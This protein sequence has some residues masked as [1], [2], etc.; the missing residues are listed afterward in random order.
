MLFFYCFFSIAFFLS[1]SHIPFDNS[2]KPKI[3]DKGVFET[4]LKQ[5]GL[6][7]FEG[8]R[9]LKVDLTIIKKDGKRGVKLFSNFKSKGVPLCYETDSEFRVSV[10][11]CPPGVEPM[12]AEVWTK[13]K[14]FTYESR[15]LHIQR[16][17]DVSWPIQDGDT[18][19]FVFDL[20][21]N[22]QNPANPSFSSQANAEQTVVRY[23]FLRDLL[24]ERESESSGEE[25]DE[26]MEIESSASSNFI[27]STSRSP[28]PTLSEPLLLCHACGSKLEAPIERQL[29]P[30]KPKASHFPPSQIDKT[31]SLSG[32]PPQPQLKD[33]KSTGSSLPSTQNS[34]LDLMEEGD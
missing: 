7:I 29:S 21:R 10:R 31:E 23:L 11:D 22:A 30:F 19:E 6:K 25:D 20:C 12:I 3:A 2:T 32:Q 15:N 5:Q 13:K 28:S 4:L 9:A 16:K 18:K 14:I 34:N 8:K 17:E 33:S 24:S 1:F 26:L 27:R